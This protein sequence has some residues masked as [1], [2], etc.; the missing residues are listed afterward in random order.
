MLAKE[1]VPDS[2]LA[3]HDQWTKPVFKNPGCRVYRIVQEVQNRGL[4]TNEQLRETLRPYVANMS[5]CLGKAKTLEEIVAAINK[6]NIYRQRKSD[7]SL[8]KETLLKCLKT[9]M[10]WATSSEQPL[11]TILCTFPDEFVPL[12]WDG[13]FVSR[14]FNNRN[15]VDGFFAT[16]VPTARAATQQHGTPVRLLEL[17]YRKMGVRLI[18]FQGSTCRLYMFPTTGI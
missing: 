13:G 8:P 10:T 15:V 1:H 5:K 3:Q 7:P 16:Q 2:A 6:N 12:P 11:I 9:H 4:A 17:F 18:I 14:R